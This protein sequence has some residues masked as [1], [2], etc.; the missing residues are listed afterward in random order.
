MD[1]SFMYVLPK[2]DRG[3][4]V[5]PGCQTRNWYCALAKTK[6]QSW[7]KACEDND[8]E[9]AKTEQKFIHLDLACANTDILSFFETLIFPYVVISLYANPCHSKN[10]RGMLKC[11]SWF[12]KKH[13][14]RK[15]VF[16]F[17]VWH[18]NISS[19]NQEAIKTFKLRNG[20][21]YCCLNYVCSMLW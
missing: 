13:R 11:Y 7:C 12:E 8:D 16:V 18:T 20:K 21:R 15:F 4:T 5:L 2:F 9:T 6:N 10:H 3:M 17:S 1:G 14:K 19:T